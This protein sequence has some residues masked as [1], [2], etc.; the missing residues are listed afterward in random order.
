MSKKAEKNRGGE[1][2]RN[3]PAPKNTVQKKKIGN[4]NSGQGSRGGGRGGTRMTKR[5]AGGPV[6]RLKKGGGGGERPSTKKKSVG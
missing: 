1:T 5:K 3:Q 4:K 2:L 6:P